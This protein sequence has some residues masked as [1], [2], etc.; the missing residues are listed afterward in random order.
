MSSIADPF[1]RQTSPAGCAIK[2]QQI[3][4]YSYGINV[5]ETDLC[6]IAADNGWYDVEIGM[7]K[8]DNGKLL[9]CFGIGYQHSQ[10]NGIEDILRQKQQKHCVMV[11]LNHEKLSG[12]EDVYNQ[13]AHAVLIA[14]VDDTNVH[15]TNPATGCARETYSIDT[16]FKA[17]KDS[18]CY[19]LTTTEDMLYVYDPSRRMMIEMTE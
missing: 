10:G 13:A 7:H 1:I 3:I 18:D 19:M 14:D 6:A 11:C 16:F 9:G 15:I 17:W 12:G 8:H 2:C 5:S 4:L